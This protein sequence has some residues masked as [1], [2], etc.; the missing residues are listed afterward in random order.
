MHCSTQSIS[1][2]IP[3]SALH[4]RRHRYFDRVSHFTVYYYIILRI[5][6]LF[7]EWESFD[8]DYQHTFSCKF[9]GFRI[10]IQVICWFSRLI[11]SLS[12]FFLPLFP[13][14]RY[15]KLRIVFDRK[16]NYCA[17]RYVVEYWRKVI[18]IR[19]YVIVTNC[20]L[21]SYAFTWCR[22]FGVVHKIRFHPFFLSF[23]FFSFVC[24]HIKCKEIDIVRFNSGSHVCIYIERI[25]Q[26]LYWILLHDTWDDLVTTNIIQNILKCTQ[27]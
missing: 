27:A 14:F 17:K 1:F 19:R 2:S 13:I 11:Y 4:L 15:R 24:A 20:A 5:I 6:W 16:Q 7:C 3:L 23:L 22:L 10:L 8:L 18:T 25:V 21:L 9:D 26:L 12:S